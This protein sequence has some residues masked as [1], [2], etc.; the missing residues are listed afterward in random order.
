MNGFGGYTAD[1]V[2]RMFRMYEKRAD[3]TAKKAYRN[4]V[5]GVMATVLAFT[6]T[7]EMLSDT[8]EDSSPWVFLVA[9][10]VDAVIGTIMGLAVLYLVVKRPL[11]KLMKIEYNEGHSQNFIDECYR[12]IDKHPKESSIKSVLALTY[13]EQGNFN[14]AMTELTHVNA[15]AFLSVPNGGELYY[16][17][18]LKASLLRGDMDG[19]AR[20]Y[21]DGRYYLQ[22]YM[23][24]PVSGDITSVALATYEYFIGHYEISVQLLEN[25]RRVLN[26]RGMREGKNT[27]ELTSVEINYMQAM[28]YACM[29]RKADAWELLNKSEGLFKSE[30]YER[31]IKKLLEDMAKS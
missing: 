14:M 8:F 9:L 22:T 23:N 2:G 17:A 28:N 29:G 25:A 6:L 3:W 19:A 24:S 30:Y 7:V 31:C 16:S 20:A 18:L 10:A 12:M 11:K 27:Y 21:N 1:Q 5:L 4:T 26:E 15:A 13:I